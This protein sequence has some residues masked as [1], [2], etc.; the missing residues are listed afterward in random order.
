MADYLCLRKCEWRGSI[1]DADVKYPLE[2]KDNP[3][4]H[5]KLIEE[6]T[7]GTASVNA[8]QEQRASLLAKAKVLDVAVGEEWTLEQLAHAIAQA[9]SNPPKLPGN[10]TPAQ[11]ESPKPKAKAKDA[12][13]APAPAQD[14]DGK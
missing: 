6:P 2:P 5:F 9:E 12:A 7:M 4:H 10:D 3:P 13:P 11:A 8:L 14:G 1:Y